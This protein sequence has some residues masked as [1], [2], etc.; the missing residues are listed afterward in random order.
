MVNGIFFIL[1][2][3]FFL[4][5][6]LCRPAFKTKN[7]M[8]ATLPTYACIAFSAICIIAVCN[9]ATHQIITATLAAVLALAT[10]KKA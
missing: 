9:G 8:K 1:F 7:T 5:I 2:V 3:H 6:T 4:C 10:T